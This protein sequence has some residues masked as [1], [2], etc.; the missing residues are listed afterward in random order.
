MISLP[1]ECRKPHKTSQCKE[2]CKFT[3]SIYE[4]TAGWCTHNTVS[5]PPEIWTPIH[6]IKK[7]ASYTHLQQLQMKYASHNHKLKISRS[8]LVVVIRTKQSVLPQPLCYGTERTQLPCE[9]ILDM[10]DLLFWVKW[11]PL[12]HPLL[13]VWFHWNE[14][15]LSIATYPNYH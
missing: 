6:N 2:G 14:S 7:L 1:Q 13:S 15:T 12:S 3:L 9:N 4:H 8:G 5:F 11:D 10:D